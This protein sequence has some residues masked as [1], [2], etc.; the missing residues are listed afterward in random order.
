MMVDLMNYLSDE[1]APQ[2]SI[3]G[4]LLDNHN[5]RRVDR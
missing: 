2:T 4:T 1:L 5:M 3:H